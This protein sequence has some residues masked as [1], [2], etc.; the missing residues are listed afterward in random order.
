MPA[1]PPDSV[2]TPEER[3]H[4]MWS[5]SP[6]DLDRLGFSRENAEAANVCIFQEPSGQWRLGPR[7][8]FYLAH[9]AHAIDQAVV[10]LPDTDN[11]MHML[12]RFALD[13]RN[14]EPVRLTQEDSATLSLAILAALSA[15]D[16]LWETF[17]CRK[18]TD[19]EKGIVK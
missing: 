9:I 17:N 19:E 4:Q 11:Q 16:G 14:G 6:R 2:L 12:R 3:A 15:I 7:E 5:V 10:P 13:H 1:L 18:L 8:M